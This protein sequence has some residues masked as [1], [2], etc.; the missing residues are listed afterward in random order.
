MPHVQVCLIWHY[1]MTVLCRSL[2]LKVFFCHFEKMLCAVCFR[3]LWLDLRFW[4][5]KLGINLASLS[6]STVAARGVKKKHRHTAI[7]ATQSCHFYRVSVHVVTRWAKKTRRR[8]GGGECQWASQDWWK[9][10]FW[11]SCGIGAKIIFLN[12]NMFWTK[13]RHGGGWFFR[14]FSG[15]QSGD[16]KRWTFSTSIFRGNYHLDKI[17]NFL[18]P[19]EDSPIS[20][21]PNLVNNFVTNKHLSLEGRWIRNS[22]GAYVV[23]ADPLSDIA[24]LQVKDE[25]SVRDPAKWQEIQSVVDSSSIDVM[26]IGLGWVSL[27]SG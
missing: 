16:S 2:G 9:L 14:W 7:G 18:F 10:G 24:V 17:E 19:R 13:K 20:C 15:F 4:P 11:H 26:L 12:K 21:L 6:T 22:W 5:T 3:M 27:Y 23:G 1:N 8:W 25:A